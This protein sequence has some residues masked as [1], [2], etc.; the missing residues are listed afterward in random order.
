MSKLKN[1]YS[2]S[3]KLLKTLAYVF[4]SL[5]SPLVIFCFTGDIWFILTLLLIPLIT[6]PPALFKNTDN[7]TSG[8]N[9]N[10]IIAL[11]YLIITLAIFGLFNIL[12][13]HSYPIIIKLVKPL[14]N[15]LSNLSNY[16]EF[17]CYF[18]CDLLI[19]KIYY[20]E[21]VIFYIIALLPLYSVFITCKKITIIWSNSKLNK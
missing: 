14:A 13:N 21:I 4:L 1:L 3:T 19:D 7:K 5:I 15:V 17:H 11:L 2:F 12:K 20:I 6:I 9:P 8:N 18:I 16:S 10:K